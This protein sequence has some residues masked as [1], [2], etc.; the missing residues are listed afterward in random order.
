MSYF[1]RCASLDELKAAYKKLALEHHPDMGGD[2]HTMQEVNAEITYNITGQRP[3]SHD[4]STC[5]GCH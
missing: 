1:D 4:C 5:G 3:C 2:V